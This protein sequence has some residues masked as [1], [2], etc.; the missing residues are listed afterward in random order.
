MRAL[1]IGGTGAV[2]AAVARHTCAIGI[3]THVGVRASSH[4]D[5][6]ASCPDIRRHLFEL[7]EAGSVARLIEAAEP[8]WIVMAAFPAGGHGD[9]G[10]ARQN[11][12]RGM[13]A[14]LLSLMEAIGSVGFSGNLTWIGSATS[15][16]HGE[17]IRRCDDALRPS[18]FRGAVKAAE[19]VL[20]GQMAA[21]L[22][23]GLTELRVFTGYGP[24]EQRNR[25]ISSLLRAGLQDDRVALTASS[26]NRDWV[27]FEDIARACVASAASALPKQ[28]VFNVCSGQLHGAHEVA[29][30]LEQIIGKRLIA[31]HAYAQTDRY[32]IALPGELPAVTGGLD[33]APRID[34]R[35][36]L[37]RGW[38]WACTPE[39]RSY[40]LSAEQ[41]AA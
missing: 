14:G 34:F 1:I 40:L 32:G 8:D 20:A 35:E 11:L 10:P 19:S 9:N 37:E 16:G 12:L 13:T 21:D 22:G 25:L 38:R 27:H 33:W 6:I 36:G 3:D 4:L 7:T 39:G 30:L 18:T 31:D 15:Y 26:A 2:G 28:R 41:V 24:F 17:Q 5:R 29:R 23:I